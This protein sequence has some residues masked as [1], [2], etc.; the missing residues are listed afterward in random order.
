M[1]FLCLIAIILIL[2]AYILYK[3]GNA[4]SDY[5]A[6][7]GIK[8]QTPSFLLGNSGPLF[9]GKKSSPEFMRDMYNEFPD[10]RF[11]VAHIL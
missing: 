1:L 9:L 11:V 8:S 2:L 6:D 3:K 5:F 4:N 7:K 10:E